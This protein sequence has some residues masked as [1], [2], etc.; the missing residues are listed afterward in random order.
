MGQLMSNCDHFRA[1]TAYV[2][3]WISAQASVGEESITDWLLYDLSAKV[4]S[5]KYFKFTKHQE[6]RKTGADWEWWFV[7]NQLSLRMR[8][9][10]K[11][12]RYGADA[13]P[14]LAYANQH[15]LQIDKLLNDAHSNNSLAFYALYVEPRPYTQ[16]CRG[17]VRHRPPVQAIYTAS[18]DSIKRLFV[19]PTRQFVS[20]ADVVQHSNPIECLV[21]CPYT[22]AAGGNAIDGL[23][24]FIDNYFRDSRLREDE[25]IS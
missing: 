7:G 8:I 13:Y 6:A 25:N 22:N 19:A 23:V 4:G 11:R 14:S 2:A 18:A 21:C 5:L 1:A 17:P 24:K 10:A 9:Q 3:S 16:L 15:G 12:L 20:V